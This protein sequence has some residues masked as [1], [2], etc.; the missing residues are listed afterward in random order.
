MSA[1]PIPKR[2]LRDL[3]YH[4]VPLVICYP[5]IAF[6]C[7][8]QCVLVV[9]YN[10]ARVDCQ[11]DTK[12]IGLFRIKIPENMKSYRKHRQTSPAADIEADTKTTKK[13]MIYN[14]A[15]LFYA[16]THAITSAIKLSCNTTSVYFHYQSCSKNRLWR[17]FGSLPLVL[18]PHL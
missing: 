5:T 17:W 10:I 14:E 15:E 2:E 12:L 16:K 4:Q 7:L 3:L 1:I 6:N 18:P 11:N 9:E 8:L 13:N